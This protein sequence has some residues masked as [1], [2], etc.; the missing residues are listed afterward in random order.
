MVT[1]VDTF[2]IISFG[3]PSEA[4]RLSIARGLS[5][6]TLRQAAVQHAAKEMAGVPLIKVIRVSPLGKPQSALSFWA[7]LV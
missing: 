6:Q 5:W 1:V 2:L 7:P 4:I 3:I